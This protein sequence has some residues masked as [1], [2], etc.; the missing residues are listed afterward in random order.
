M[1]GSEPMTRSTTPGSNDMSNYEL[2]IRETAQ[3]D[4]EAIRAAEQEDMQILLSAVPGS[5]LYEVI[6]NTDDSGIDEG[7]MRLCDQDIYTG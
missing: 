6:H 3:Y 7:W 5:W 1:G 4:D 2:Q